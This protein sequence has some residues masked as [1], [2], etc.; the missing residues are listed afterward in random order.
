VFDGSWVF[1][2]KAIGIGKWSGVG[3]SLFNIVFEPESSR[4]LQ[5]F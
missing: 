2:V 1:S 5:I 3:S 4:K